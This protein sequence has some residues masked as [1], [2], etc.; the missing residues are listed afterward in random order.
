MLAAIVLAAFAAAGAI[1]H[2]LASSEVGG[3][4]CG[5]VLMQFNAKH[6]KLKLDHG[7]DLQ[8]Q[9]ADKLRYS[10][11]TQILRRAQERSKASGQQ[12]EYLLD[13][14]YVHDANNPLDNNGQELSK[15]AGKVSTGRV[16]NNDLAKLGKYPAELGK[17]AATLGRGTPTKDPAKLGKDPADRGKD[18]ANLGKGTA[19]KGPATLGKYAEDYRSAAGQGDRSPRPASLTRPPLPKDSAAT[20]KQEY[21]DVSATPQQDYRS[22]AG[23]VVRSPLPKDEVV[24]LECVTRANPRVVSTGLTSVAKPGTACIFGLDDADEGAHCIMLGGKYGSYGWCYTAEDRSEWGSCN[25]RCPLSGAAATLAKRVDAMDEMVGVIL[26]KVRNTTDKGSVKKIAKAP[27]MA[28]HTELTETLKRASRMDSNAVETALG[29]Q[30]AHA[31]EDRAGAAS[32]A[33]VPKGKVGELAVLF[34]NGLISQEEFDA[35]RA[36]AE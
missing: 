10:P 6:Q 15:K 18:L 7:E 36:E 32:S 12:L 35:L 3:G 20:S 8:E 27:V 30:P 26:E 21:K 4:A 23:Q 28:D 16:Q 25:D 34:R 31:P 9:A 13:V 33:A 11:L 19:T 17:D 5:T 22:A 2:V 24:K 14:D 1:P 29:D